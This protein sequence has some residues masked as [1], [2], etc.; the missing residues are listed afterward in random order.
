MRNIVRIYKENKKYHAYVISNL[1]GVTVCA[2]T[3]RGASCKSIDL[4]AK[5]GIQSDVFF[6]LKQFQQNALY[7][8]DKIIY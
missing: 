3:I 6:I 5:P 1:T 4:D 7:L 8:A 2:S